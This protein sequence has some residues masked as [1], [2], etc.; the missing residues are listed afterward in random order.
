MLLQAVTT[1]TA[2]A[3]ADAMGSIY[4]A[5]ISSGPFGIIA[6]IALFWAY[7]K[8]KQATKLQETVGVKQE[9]QLQATQKLL[10]NTGR[11]VER[12]EDALSRRARRKG[13]DE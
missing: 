9:L 3:A 12:L 1:A 4:G 7:R 5:L 6:A 10:E 13:Q 11:L 2:P 8:D